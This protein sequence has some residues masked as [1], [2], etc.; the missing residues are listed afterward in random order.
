MYAARKELFH[1]ESLTNKECTPRM[2]E[3]VTVAMTQLRDE[4]IDKKKAT[5]Y[6]LSISGHIRSFEHCSKEDKILSLG[7]MITNDLAESALGGAGRNVEVGGMIGIHRAASTA[8]TSKNGFMDRGMPVQRRRKRKH[9]DGP[10]S[11][12]IKSRT[13][14]GKGMFF[15]IEKELQHCTFISGMRGRNLVHIQDLAAV[16]EQRFEK[17]AKEKIAAAKGID[18]AKTLLIHAIYRYGHHFQRRA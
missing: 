10:I 8:D 4:L 13:N 2:L 14:D 18:K 1:P 16:K 3:L 5:Y 6:N 11:R 12:R 9:D 17:R 15:L 7:A